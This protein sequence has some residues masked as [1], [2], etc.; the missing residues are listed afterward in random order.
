MFVAD[1]NRRFT[2][3]PTESGSAF[4]PLVGMYLELVLPEQH[5]RVVGKDSI[6]SFENLALQLPRGQVRLVAG[7]RARSRS[8]S[9]DA[10][11]LSSL[12]FTR[13]LTAD[14]YR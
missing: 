12:V 10:S 14:L 13:A 11:S 3:K 4:V 9:V 1:F 7:L 8:H 5:E 2:V 6:V